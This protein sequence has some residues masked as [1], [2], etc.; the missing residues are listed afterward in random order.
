MT[1]NSHPSFFFRLLGQVPTLLVLAGLAAVG[2]WGVKNEWTLP[3]DAKKDTEGDRNSWC[4]AHNVPDAICVECKPDL[5]P[6]GEE[7]GY[8]RV[9]GVHEC[10]WCH[11][12]LAQLETAY[13]VSA[14]ELARAKAALEFAPRT[15]NGRNDVLHKRRIQFASLDAYERA[16]VEVAPSFQGRIAETSAVHGEITHDPGRVAHVSSRAP[17]SVFKVFQHLG[18]TIREGDLLALV[19]SAAVGLAK[20]EYQQWLAQLDVRVQARNKMDV[21]VVPAPTVLTADA[22]IREARIKLASARQALINLG[23]PVPADDFKGLSDDQVS[24]RLHFLGIP[25]DHARGLDPRA[26]SNN[27]LPIRAPIP[28]I[29][30]SR[31]IVSGDVV[32][33]AKVLFEVVDN[34]VVWLN[35]GVRNE[36]VPRLQL[37]RTR[38][39]FEPDGQSR[40]I[41]G[42]VAW[43]SS[44]ADHKTRTVRVRVNLDNQDARLRANTF[45]HGHVVLREEELAVLVPNEALHAEGGNYY[46]FVRDRRFR[47]DGFPKVFHTRTVRVGARDDRHVE[48]IAGVL[49]GE[50]VATHGSTIL[51]AELLRGKIGEG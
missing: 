41:E 23:L 16:A 25:P 34:R 11:P 24:E 8:C 30:T 48:I 51:M 39:V 44:E 42:V 19:D 47:D 22:A 37:G 40:P 12:E 32:D 2:Y 31:D 1:S 50:L 17:G 26:T 35:V 4:G 33:P 36:D 21:A 5:L 29:I 18:D 13:P 28:G 45:G 3:H 14:A 10:T 49:P 6:R 46:M 38:I 27:L 15:V 7:F 9:H 20:A 43:I